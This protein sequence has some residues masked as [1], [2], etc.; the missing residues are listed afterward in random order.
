MKP[1]DLKT[2]GAWTKQKLASRHVGTFRQHFI[3]TMFFLLAV[4]VPAA[5]LR[6]EDPSDENRLTLSV[7]HPISGDLSGFGELG[8][9]WNPDE[10]YQ[11]Y[12][13]VYPGLTYKAAKWLQFS[14]GLR[15]LF[16]DNDDKAN[17]LELR[18]FAGIKLFLPNNIKW[19]IFNYTRYE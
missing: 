9:R 18:P 8:F 15:T 17:S 14:A 7:N 13:I 4:T 5:S 10:D 3:L 2:R 19:T 6:A 16:T 1:G 11:A 12:T